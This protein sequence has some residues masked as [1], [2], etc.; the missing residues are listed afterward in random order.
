MGERAYRLRFT[1]HCC[2][3][4]GVIVVVSG[5]NNTQKPRGNDSGTV[6]VPTSV[7]R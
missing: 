6:G 7:Q 3:A 1:E 5:T 4:Y 2:G